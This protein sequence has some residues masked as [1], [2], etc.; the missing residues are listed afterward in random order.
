MQ[1]LLLERARIGDKA[2]RVEGFQLR[3]LRVLLDEVDPKHEW[4]GLKKV[5][6]LRVIIFGFA[7]VMRRSIGSSFEF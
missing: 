4:G 7:V 2:G 3:A 6:I 1:R 5:L